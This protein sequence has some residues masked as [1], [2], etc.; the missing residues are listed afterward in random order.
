MKNMCQEKFILFSLNRYENWNNQKIYFYSKNPLKPKGEKKEYVTDPYFLES[1]NKPHIFYEAIDEVEAVNRIGH[2][3][4]LIDKYTGVQDIVYHHSS[5]KSLLKAA[6]YKKP[7]C[8]LSVYIPKY[9]NGIGSDVRPHQES[10]FAYTEPQT[11]VVLWVALED[12]T[13]ENACMWGI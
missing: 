8:Q 2:G 10:S 9:P 4:H 1:R 13:I 12:A 6:G 5:L 7:I 3:M 11:V